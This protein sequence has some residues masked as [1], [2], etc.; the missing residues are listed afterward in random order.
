MEIFKLRKQYA[1]SN[2]DRIDIRRKTAARL[3]KAG[4][5]IKDIASCLNV[6]EGVVMNYVK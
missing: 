3:R 5:S 1:L 6:S 4:F 2:C